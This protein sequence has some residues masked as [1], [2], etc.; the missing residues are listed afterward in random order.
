MAERA[1]ADRAA[2]NEALFRRVNERVEDIN[3]AFEPILGETDFFCEC[4]DID[5]I[6]GSGCRSRSMRRSGRP[7]SSSR[8]SP[9][10]RDPRTERAIE[11]RVG[12]VIVET[13]PRRRARR[14]TRSA[15]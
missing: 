3:K 9:A 7:P 8:S 4:A 5:C 11:E 12:Y 1:E 2:R 6:G 13:R 15:R 10:T 14:A